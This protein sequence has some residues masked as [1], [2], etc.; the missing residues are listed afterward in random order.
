MPS[1]RTL[2][3]LALLAPWAAWALVR[4]LGLDRVHPVVAAMSFTPYAALTA[5]VP[6]LA[7]LVLR[8]RGVALGGVAVG[9]VLALAVLPRAFGGERVPRGVDGPELR[10]MSVNVFVGRADMGAVLRLARAERVDVLCLQELTPQALA[11]FDA[12]GGRAAFP[13]RAAEPR[14]HAAGSAVLARR[15]LT[16]RAPDDAT[17]AEQPD[18]L[19]RVP[20]AQPVRIKTVHPYPPLNAAREPRWRATLD[21]LPR[22]EGRGPLRIV[23]GDFNATLDH[24]PFRAVLAGGYVDAADAT[25][26]GLVHTWSEP[27]RPALTIDHVLLDARLG[28]RSYAVRDVPGTDHRAIVATVVLPAASPGRAAQ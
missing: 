24:A 20:G 3:A 11:R 21:E 23:A 25:G 14:T 22:P 5:V 9:A 27:R 8:R 13:G 2:L 4:T 6:I 18:V 15:A 28:V 7:A 10:V 19:L 12:A 26:H 16:D 17:A 1:R